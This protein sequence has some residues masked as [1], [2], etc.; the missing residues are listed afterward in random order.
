MKQI[1]YKQKLSVYLIKSTSNIV[2]TDVF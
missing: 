1:A 2:N